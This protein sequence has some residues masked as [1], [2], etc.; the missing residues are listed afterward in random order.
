MVKRDIVISLL[1]KFVLLV[2]LLIKGLV[3]CLSNKSVFVYG[4]IFFY[5]N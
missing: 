2:N 3:S 5:P 4:G 1:A